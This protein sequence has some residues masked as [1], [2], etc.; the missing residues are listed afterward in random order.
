MWSMLLTPAYA[1]SIRFAPA[2]PTEREEITVLI[3]RPHDPTCVVAVQTPDGRVRGLTFPAPEV[4]YPQ[5]TM[6]LYATLTCAPG[7][8]SYMFTKMT[9]WDADCPEGDCTEAETTA[10]GC[11][12]AA[13]A[14]MLGLV[15]LRRR[16]RPTGR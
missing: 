12:N 9:I 14:A 10:G 1:Q 13:T 3:D 6:N 5:A 4:E 11:G 7:H 2:E 8:V 16:R 15:P